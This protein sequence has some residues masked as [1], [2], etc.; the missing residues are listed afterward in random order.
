MADG[1]EA[2]LAATDEAPSGSPVIEAATQAYNQA[3]AQTHDRHVPRQDLS[4]I[5]ANATESAD[6]HNSNRPQ[7]RYFD[8]VRDLFRT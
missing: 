4:H 8:P 7:A 3:M 1:D 2:D 6:A 5:A